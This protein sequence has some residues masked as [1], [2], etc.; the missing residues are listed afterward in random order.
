MSKFLRVEGYSFSILQK[1]ESGASVLAFLFRKLLA[2][3]LFNVLI[4][5]MLSDSSR[6]YI[7]D[8]RRPLYF[9]S[10]HE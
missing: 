3:Y 5:H 7:Y 4:C 9:A 10:R 8:G 1:R 2:S 6:P